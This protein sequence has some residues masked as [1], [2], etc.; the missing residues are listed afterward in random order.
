MDIFTCPPE[1]LT[2]KH[3]AYLLSTSEWGVGQLVAQK[4]LIP[5]DDGGKWQKFRLDDVRSYIASLHEWHR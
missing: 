4:K 5:V 3:V 2:K 1:L